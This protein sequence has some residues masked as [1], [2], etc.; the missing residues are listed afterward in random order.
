MNSGQAV[1]ALTA[2]AHEYRL[3]VYRML[4]E[5]GPAGLN[6]GT[7]AV[8]D[9]IEGVRARSCRLTPSAH[10]MSDCADLRLSIEYDRRRF[11]GAV[12]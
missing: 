6:A 10:G 7:I 11:F 3:G 5:A 2:L 1:S 9:T 8:G 4:V 12:V